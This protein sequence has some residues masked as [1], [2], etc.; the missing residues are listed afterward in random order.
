V[1]RMLQGDQEV[2]DRF[3]LDDEGPPPHQLLEALWAR[4]DALEELASHHQ[5]RSIKGAMLQGL[6]G[7]SDIEDAWLVLSA[8]LGTSAETRA[9]HLARRRIS[10][11]LYSVVYLAP[12]ADLD[13]DLVLLRDEYAPRGFHDLER[14]DQLA[15]P[16]GAQS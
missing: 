3:E 11:L 7:I 14:I 9:A 1:R 16:P 8:N 4:K 10:R 6:I 15:A 12:D 13:K 2:I 5:A